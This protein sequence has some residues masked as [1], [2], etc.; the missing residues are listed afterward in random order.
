MR[1]FYDAYNAQRAEDAKLLCARKSNL[2]VQAIDEYVASES[3]NLKTLEYRNAT[4]DASF[5]EALSTKL[6]VGEKIGRV[7]LSDIKLFVN[8]IYVI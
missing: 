8:L 5:F 1:K 6:A 2:I 7:S 3:E 4:F